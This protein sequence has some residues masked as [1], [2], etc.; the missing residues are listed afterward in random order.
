[1]NAGDESKLMTAFENY[2]AAENPNMVIL[3]D[4]NKGVLTPAVIDKVIA[5]CKENNIL[6]VELHHKDSFEDNCKSRRA[7]FSFPSSLSPADS[8][9]PFRA[10]RHTNQPCTCHPPCTLQRLFLDPLNDALVRML[11]SDLEKSDAVS[12]RAPLHGNK[13]KQIDSMP[14]LSA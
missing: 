6:F 3:E 7:R 14:S 1:M 12:I 2:I 5:C 4:Y 9:T 8:G 11:F 10:S 13:L